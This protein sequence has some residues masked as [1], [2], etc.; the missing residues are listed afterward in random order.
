MS[1]ITRHS[2]ERHKK[3]SK[4]FDLNHDAVNHLK[5]KWSHYR[6]GVAH[7][8]GRG[9]ALLFHDRG[10]RRGW[11]VCSTPRPHFTP[12]KDPVPILQEDGWAP[13][14]VWTGGKSRPHRD[15]IPDCPAQSHSLYRL[16]YLAN[17]VNHLRWLFSAETLQN[18]RQFNNQF[19]CSHT[20]QL[21]CSVHFICKLLTL[22]VRK[23]GWTLLD[24][25]SHAFL[26]II[27]QEITEI[28][29]KIFFT[30]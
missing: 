17:T 1:C 3:P 27:L 7:R 10:T 13:G 24:K 11:V 15:S 12:G 23:V 4:H 6:P 25:R 14:P 8:V 18:I 19:T 9:T 21:W 16:S 5:V 30:R 28:K 29:T 26:T 22:V 20:Y 2:E